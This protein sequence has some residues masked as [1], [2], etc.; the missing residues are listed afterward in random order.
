MPSDF[1]QLADMRLVS[2]ITIT[3]TTTTII[4]III[5]IIIIT[6]AFNKER[7]HNAVETDIFG[8]CI[9]GH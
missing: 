7:V 6:I 5:I 9:H 3:T 1:L 4:I 8:L 2:V